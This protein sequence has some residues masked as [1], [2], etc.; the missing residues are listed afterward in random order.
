MFG[1]ITELPHLR[2]WQEAFDHYSSI[3]PLRGTD[4]RPIC[5]TK[6]G[7]RKKQYQIEMR[8]NN[9]IACVLYATDVLLFHPDGEITFNAGGYVSAATHSFA[10][11]IL[12]GNT[13]N[14]RALFLTK[15]GRT[16]IELSTG[17]VLAVERDQII[18]LRWKAEKIVDR[19]TISGSGGCLVSDTGYGAYE[20]IDKPLMYSYFV[21]R[22]KL[23]EHRQKVSKFCQ[24]CTAYAKLVDPKDYKDEPKALS[25]MMPVEDIYSLMCGN[26][27][28]QGEAIEW[29]LYKAN[30]DGWMR[31]MGQ[32]GTAGMKRSAGWGDVVYYT[33]LDAIPKLIDDIIKYVFFKEVFNKQEVDKPNTNNNAR[34]S[35][36]IHTYI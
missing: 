30:R 33:D 28:A 26:M 32:P 20:F 12:S 34:Y 7:R 36:G 6:N 21:N 2:T 9:D 8:D 24:T 18:K 5:A 19:G 31:F 17:D 25:A 1:H 15:K 11:R 35:S 4:I 23:N 3:T 13:W 22:K 16:T 14:Y 10:T 27:E 29:F